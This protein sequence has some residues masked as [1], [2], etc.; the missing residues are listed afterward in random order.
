MPCTNFIGPIT[1]ILITSCPKT[2]VKE[3]TVNKKTV[4]NIKIPF[5][6]LSILKPSFLEISD[7]ISDDS[8][9]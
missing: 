7:E 5:P 8:D 4:A 2:D 9:Y 6:H 3:N 1:P